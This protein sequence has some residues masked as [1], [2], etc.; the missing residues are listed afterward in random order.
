MVRCLLF[1]ACICYEHK[2]IKVVGLCKVPLKKKMTKRLRLPHTKVIYL[3]GAK[4]H[5][6]YLHWNT[7]F[8]KPYI[9]SED[10]QLWVRIKVPIHEG[11]CCRE[12]V[13]EKVA[14]NKNRVLFTLKGHVAGTCGRT[15]SQ[16]VRAGQNVAETWLPLCGDTIPCKGSV[17]NVCPDNMLHDLA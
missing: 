12:K 1:F 5:E 2:L 8:T 4:I 13:V 17:R 16:L 15:K 3:N 7:V 6:R 11:T 14:R 9:Q 10:G